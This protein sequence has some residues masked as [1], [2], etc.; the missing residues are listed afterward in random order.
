MTSYA[1]HLAGHLRLVLLRSLAEAPGYAGNSAFL[2]DAADFVGI[3][4]SQDLVETQLHWL[5][6]QGLVRIESLPMGV[7]VATLAERGLD[8][9][10]ARATVPG[11]RRPSPKG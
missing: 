10:T 5:A 7:T 6:E 1:D 11:V 9:A 4:V 3:R 2:R 8:V